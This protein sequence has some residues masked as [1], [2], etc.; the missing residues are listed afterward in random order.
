[1]VPVLL[2]TRLEVYS[3]VYSLYPVAI[4]E[5][6][7]FRGIMLGRLIPG[8]V[9]LGN[10]R[11]V[12]RALPAVLLSS[13]YFTLA[14]VPFYIVQGSVPELP[15]V[16]L[17]GVIS[18]LIYVLTGGVVVDVALHWFTDYLAFMALG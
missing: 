1:V 8:G 9:D 17:Y 4:S 5:E 13:A 18:G 3:V 16:F 12:P 2:I 6:V 7:L 10:Y 15:L 11:A 14:H